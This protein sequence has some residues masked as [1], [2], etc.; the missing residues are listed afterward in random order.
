MPQDQ[1]GENLSAPVKAGVVAVVIIG[2]VIFILVNIWPQLFPADTADARRRRAQSRRDSRQ[3]EERVFG[4]TEAERAEVFWEMG[5]AE[6]RADR[7]AEA[8]HPSSVRPGEYVELNRILINRYYDEI[9][10]EH[11]GLTRAQLLQI[12]SEGTRKHWR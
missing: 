8:Q 1:S 12:A 3:T 7:E 9:C 5:R 6:R 11:G 2:A 10:A 4:L